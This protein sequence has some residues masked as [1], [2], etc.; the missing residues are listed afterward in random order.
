MLEDFF[1]FTVA[2]IHFFP[3]VFALLWDV[4]PAIEQ[5]MKLLRTLSFKPI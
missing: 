1:L 5:N 4:Q 3:E 2:Q